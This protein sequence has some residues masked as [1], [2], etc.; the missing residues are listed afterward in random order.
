VRSDEDRLRDVLDAI[1]AIERRALGGREAFDADEMLRVWCLHRPTVIGEAVSGVSQA[2]RSKYPSTPWRRI[3]AMR[4]AVVPSSRGRRAHPRC[5]GLAIVRESPETAAVNSCRDKAV[6]RLIGARAR[7]GEEAL[8]GVAMGGSAHLDVQGTRDVDVAAGRRQLGAVALGHCVQR[9]AGAVS[10]PRGQGGAL[11]AAG[12]MRAAW[13]CSQ[14]GLPAAEL[15]GSGDRDGWGR[16]AHGGGYAARSGGRTA[17][18]RRSG[19]RRRRPIYGIWGSGRRRGGR[20][21]GIRRGGV[22]AD[23][24]GASSSTAAGECYVGRT[25]MNRQDH[26]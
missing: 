11:V 1:G 17:A 18:M 5:G 6:V 25:N 20:S 2:L 14:G 24:L 3:I 19:A 15:R 4:N 9:G 8:P 7:G 22:A 10:S 21:T 12:A 16:T 26:K 23:L 13:R